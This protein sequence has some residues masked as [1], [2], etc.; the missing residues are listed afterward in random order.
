M[1]LQK[2]FAVNLLVVILFSCTNKPA[3]K[4]T[5]TGRDSEILVV[6]EKSIWD[7][8]A[9]EAIRAAL[10]QQMPG[11]PAPEPE[12]TIINVPPGSFGS[13]FK[14]HRNI[15]IVD[16][17]PGSN[18]QAV[19]FNNKWSHPQQI[20]EISAGSD[21]GFNDL[22]NRHAKVIR[23]LYL[24]NEHKRYLMNYI[25]SRNLKL[26]DVVADKFNIRIKIPSGYYQAKL[27]SDFM[28]L[29]SETT[30]MSFGIL[31]YTFP[32]KSRAQLDTAS[33]LNVRDAFTRIHIPASVEGS[34]MKISR[35]PVAPVSIPVRFNGHFAIETRGLWCAQNDYMG[36]PFVSYYIVDEKRERFV[37][38]DGFLYYPNHDKRN[39]VRQVESVLWSAEIV[40][41]AENSMQKPK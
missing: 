17:K 27:T 20:I 6:C 15:L 4:P 12:F 29:R 13:T 36:G 1:F 16:L 34:F 22:I 31:I 19:M 11:L 7:G 38:L 41:P 26:E 18:A 30:A 24:Q 37:V 10:T 8:N 3:G 32:Y 25:S 9:G 33:I 5:A 23:E 21:S 14:P 28:W 39:Y 2:A 40:P 35:H